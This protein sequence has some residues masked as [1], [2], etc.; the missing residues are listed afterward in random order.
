MTL[1]VHIGYHKTGTTA[2]QNWLVKNRKFL[3]ERDIIFPKGMSSWPGH[4]ELAWI[5]AGNQYP[6]QDRFYNPAETAAYYTP[7]LE[8]SLDPET[9]TILSSE[10]FSRLDFSFDMMNRLHDWL[11]PYKPFIIGYFRDPLDFLMSRYRHEVQEGG[12]RRPIRE[13]LSSVDN[14]LSAN[15]FSRTLVWSECFQG[16]CI[17]RNYSDP[18]VSSDLLRSFL[19]A[20][21]VDL[22]KFP[23]DLLDSG[24]SETEVKL[25]PTLIDSIRFIHGFDESEQKMSFYSSIYDLSERLPPMPMKQFLQQIGLPEETIR[26]LD[27]LN[28]DRIDTKITI[29]P[30]SNK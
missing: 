4:P 13:Y 22:T 5:C 14:I 11:S 30:C 23:A 10:E 21:D 12:E 17:L 28:Y 9:L 27:S 3:R 15:F 6:W 20:L 24:L 1:V 26:L 8:A 18:T 2:L 7:V 19:I 29:Q 25:H 16:R